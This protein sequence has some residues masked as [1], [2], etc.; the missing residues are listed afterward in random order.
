MINKTKFGARFYNLTLYQYFKF[1][2]TSSLKRL[3]S[4]KK[5]LTNKKYI[6]LGCGLY[7]VKENFINLDF[8]NDQNNNIVFSDFRYPL[9]FENDFF[10]GAFSE[11]TLEH[12]NSF[13]SIKFL[14]EVYR[15]LIE[16]SVFRIVVPD[17]DLYIKFYNKQMTNIH[18]ENFTNGCEAIWS[19]T[20]NYGHLSVWNFEM[21]EFQLKKIGFRKI[22]KKK[23]KEGINSDLIIDKEGREI[24]SLYIE[25]VK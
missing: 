6:Q 13:N 19:L 10:F 20:Q 18:F 12:L 14:S 5:I 11:H 17:L 21:L 9:R 4:S 7:D 8:Y 2:V 15:V 22:Y 16:G 25:A 1:E 3:L 24:E 23:Y